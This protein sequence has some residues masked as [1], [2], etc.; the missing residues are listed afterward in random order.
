MF[1]SWVPKLHH[2]T[3]LHQSRITY[4]DWGSDVVD[5]SLDFGLEAMS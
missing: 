5:M 2:I 4:L 3:H 1:G